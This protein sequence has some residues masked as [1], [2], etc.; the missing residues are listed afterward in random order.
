MSLSCARLTGAVEQAVKTAATT[1]TNGRRK[2]FMMCVTRKCGK[3]ERFCRPVSPG[4]F[5]NLPAACFWL[6]S[7]PMLFA[8]GEQFLYRFSSPIGIVFGIFSIWMLIDAVR[9]K[10]WLWALFI[11]AFPGFGACWYFFYVYRG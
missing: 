7:G 9:R 3:C 5:L 2:H 10:E 1:I 6:E 11:F 4:K 8:F